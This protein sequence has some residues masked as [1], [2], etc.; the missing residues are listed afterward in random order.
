MGETSVTLV[1]K[2]K[3]LTPTQ[4]TKLWRMVRDGVVTEQEGRELLEMKLQATLGGIDMTDSDYG[5]VQ[6]GLIER[7]HGVP[8]LRKNQAFWA[9]TVGPSA[10][11]FLARMLGV[12]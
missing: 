6:P 10:V 7:W 4:K 9:V 3:D 8:R 12:M 11:L 1:F 2:H 5:P